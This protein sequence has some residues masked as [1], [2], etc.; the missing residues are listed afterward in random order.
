[1]FQSLIRVTDR[2][3]A[4]KPHPPRMTPVSQVFPYLLSLGVPPLLLAAEL[5]HLFIPPPLLS[6]LLLPQ[7]SLATLLL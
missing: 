5:L 4:E 3:C 2:R 1:M 6:L 7:L